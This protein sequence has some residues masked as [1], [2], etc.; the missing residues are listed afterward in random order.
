M[1]SIIVNIQINEVFDQVVIVVKLTKTM[2][3]QYKLYFY[4]KWE[5]KSKDF[6]NLHLSLITKIPT[7]KSS[8]SILAISK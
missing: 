1:V 6:S 5:I 2:T 7:V 8:S 3:I 4:D